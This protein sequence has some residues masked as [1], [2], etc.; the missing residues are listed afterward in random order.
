MTDPQDIRTKGKWQM[1]QKGPFDPMA[2]LLDRLAVP[3]LA[4]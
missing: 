2:R 3:L 4:R 1:A